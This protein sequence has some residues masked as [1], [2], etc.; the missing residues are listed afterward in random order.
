MTPVDPGRVRLFRSPS[1]YDRRAMRRFVDSVLEE[2]ASLLGPLL[3]AGD[4]GLAVVKPNWLYHQHA[5]QPDVWETVITHPAVLL[6]VVESLAEKMNGRGAISLCDA[7]TTQADFSAILQRG[8]LLPGLDEIRKRWPKLKLETLDLR[9]EIWIQKEEVNVERRPNTEDPRGYVRVDL[10]RDSLFYT[11]S[12][13][14]RYYGADYDQ[15]VVNEHHRGQVQEYL[16]AGTPMKCHLFV[17]VPKMKTHKKTG[18]TCCLKNLVGVNGDKN[19]LPHHTEGYP[20]IGG[21]EFPAGGLAKDVERR[22]KKAGMKMALAVP[23][24]GSWLYRKA[25]NAGKGLL[26]DSDQ[27][28]RNGNWNGNDTCWR[29]VLDLNRALLYARA[30]GSWSSQPR[31]YL[32]FVDGIIAGQGNGPGAPD[33]AEAGVVL[34][35]SNPC[36]LDA[37]AARLMGF[38]PMLLPQIAQAM[39]E[40]RWPIWRGEL[41]GIRIREEGASQ[42]SSLNELAPAIPGGFRPHF[43]WARHL[44]GTAM[45]AEQR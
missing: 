3:G 43:G 18:I 4:D 19:W 41:S 37:V 15:G 6:A 44:G 7:P 1:G 29:M 25:R 32:A 17:N 21:D 13:Q 9:R 20:A 22:F 12:G 45:T 28:V 27:V 16:I 8:E 24:L 14:G 10:G 30:D 31:P 5:H 2:N 34:A 40:H 26:G 38:D 33:P 42:A 39:A 11:H 36:V 23:G 35:G